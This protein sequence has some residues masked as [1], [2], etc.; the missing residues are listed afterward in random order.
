MFVRTI[1]TYYL[2]IIS[3]T[4]AGPDRYSALS[5]IHECIMNIPIRYYDYETKQKTIVYTDYLNNK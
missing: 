4:T 2:G 1:L 3:S 5:D